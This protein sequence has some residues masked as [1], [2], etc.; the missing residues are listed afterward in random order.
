MLLS[1]P[2]GGVVGGR[3][4]GQAAGFANLITLDVGG[5]SADIGVIHGGELRHKH[6]LDNQI[7]GLHLRLSMIDVATIGAGGGSIASVDAGGMLHVGPRSAGASPGPACYG[8]GGTEPTVTDAQLVLG[9]L[10]A[11]S[12]LGGR[13]EISHELA[14]RAVEE[15]VAGPLGLSLEQAAAGIVR[16]ATSHMIDSIEVNSVRRGYD[17]RDFALVAFGGAGPLFAPDIARE[18]E[19]PSIVAPRFPGI[20]SAMGLLE[21]DVVHHASRTLIGPL[22]GLGASTL[23]AA[24]AALEEAAER[25]LHAD[26]FPAGERAVQRVAECRYAGQGYELSVAAPPGPVDDRWLA[27]VAE[28]FHAGHEREFAHALRDAVVEVVTVGVRGIGR[29][30]RVPTREL[31]AANGPAQPTGERRVWFEDG[32]WREQTP[33]FARDALLAGHELTGPAIVEQE[34]STI[35]VPP[36]LVGH[37]D[38][39]GAIVIGRVR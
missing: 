32:G 9:R 38:I 28:A 37:V 24:Y 12:F 25:Q 27:A 7:G 11:A 13:M 14:V 10:E 3:A 8:R 17:P 21:S 26:G 1:G 20:A 5:T 16:V 23:E 29:L 30:A 2:V 19:L 35:V 6:W 18:L 34:D 22:L 36:G 39:A 31:A 33:V 15:H 4:A